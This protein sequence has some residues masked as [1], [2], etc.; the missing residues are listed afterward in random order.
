MKIA[1]DVGGVLSKYPAVFR[2]MIE[3]LLAGG[4]DVYIISDMH[5]ERKIWE[6]LTLN[7]IKIG[8]AA[9]YS[10]DF[11]THGEMCKA[12]LCESLGIDLLVDDFPGYVAHGKHVRLLVM[13]DPHE[14]YY[15]DSWKTDGSEGDFGR[16]KATHR[17]PPA[18]RAVYPETP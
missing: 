14:P 11:K 15:C 9:V 12:I 13:P 16:R 4:A 8:R 17:T 6:M 1:F 2:G 5:P 18:A 7:G 3:V 10:A